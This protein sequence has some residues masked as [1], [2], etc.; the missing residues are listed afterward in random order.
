MT[1]TSQRSDCPAKFL[2]CTLINSELSQ[3]TVTSWNDGYATPPPIPR[4]QRAADIQPEPAYKQPTSRVPTPQNQ[5]P[6]DPWR[7]MSNNPYMSDEP[8]TDLVRRHSYDVTTTWRNNQPVVDRATLLK[9]TGAASGPSSSAVTPAPSSESHSRQQ[10]TP[11]Q[12]VFT[13]T[14]EDGT[15]MSWMPSVSFEQASGPTTSFLSQPSPISD[16]PQEVLLH[17]ASSNNL[18]RSATPVDQKYELGY[19]HEGNER[20]QPPP[21]PHHPLMPNAPEKTGPKPKKPRSRSPLPK[22]EAVPEESTFDYSNEE[23]WPDMMPSDVEA[24]LTDPQ[25]RPRQQNV[26]FNGDLYTPKWVRYNGQSKEG[27][28]DT[29]SPGKWLQLKNSAYWYAPSRYIVYL[30]I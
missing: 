10:S 30:D 20:Q 13:F 27:L 4:E 17:S 6:S 19:V 18:K 12:T 14:S 23:E 9:M 24:A 21:E 1:H 11:V 3:Q 7:P 22:E 2:L 26:R 28:C 25:A 29:C 8:T 16:R 5:I 15:R